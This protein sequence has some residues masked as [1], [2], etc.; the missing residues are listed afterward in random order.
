MA[1]FV[2]ITENCKKD[3]REHGLVEEIERFR[4]RV[5]TSQSTSLFDPFPPPY[6][7]KKKLGARQNRLIAQS[8]SMG[9]HGVVLF[10][11]VMIRGHRAYEDEFAVDP[12]AYGRQHFAHLATPEDLA[13]FVAD[14]TRTIL[15]TAKPDPS[16]EEYAL[17]YSAFSH[18]SNSWHDGLVCETKEWVEQVA[19]DRIAKQLALLARPCL[20]AL[21]KE[22]GL[23]FLPVHGKPCWGAWVLKTPGRLLLVAVATDQTGARPRTWLDGSRLTCPERTRPQYSGQVVAPIPR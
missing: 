17:L 2:F 22:D 14:R 23:H 18:H 3:A 21:M 4:D 15:D 11:A 7:V 6:L 5:E 10:L 13:A 8:H 12:V 19:Q 20:D 9:G 16:D 1:L